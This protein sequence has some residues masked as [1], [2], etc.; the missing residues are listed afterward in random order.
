[1]KFAQSVVCKVYM[2]LHQ[3]YMGQAS[4]Y[5]Q[6]SVQRPLMIGYTY[7]NKY[8]LRQC[9]VYDSDKCKLLSFYC[10]EDIF[11]QNKFAKCLAEEGSVYTQRAI[12]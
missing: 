5:C 10:T 1:M 6:V 9:D 4:Q 3:P 2:Q 7:T 8:L 12:L 11:K